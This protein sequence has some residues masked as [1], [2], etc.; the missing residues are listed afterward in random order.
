[1]Y[2]ILKKVKIANPSFYEELVNSLLYSKPCSEKSYHYLRYIYKITNGEF[3]Q[4]VAQLYSLF[5]PKKSSDER[6]QIFDSRQTLDVK[7]IVRNIQ[8]EGIFIFPEKLN[9]NLLDELYRY[10]M[11]LQVT[12]VARKLKLK[13]S[14][15]IDRKKF[16]KSRYI[17]ELADIVSCK[18]FQK[19]VTDA[20]LLSLSQEYL[21][22][23]P[24]LD[25]I[26]L[27][28]SV[29]LN[30]SA[31]L[32]KELSDSA[33]KF[34]YDL[35]RIKFIKFFIYLNEVNLDNGPF[36]Y[37]KG[38]HNKKHPNF[39]DGRY[40][41]EEIHKLY[42][43]DSI[44]EVTGEPGTIFACDTLGF[45]KGKPLKE[46]FRLVLQLEYSISLFGAEFQ[47]Q[48]VDV[49][50]SEVEF[51][52]NLSKNKECYGGRFNLS[53]QEAPKL[54]SKKKK[55]HTFAG[56]P[57]EK[58]KYTVNQNLNSYYSRYVLSRQ[59]KWN[60]KKLLDSSSN[61]IF[62]IGSCFANE[63]RAY[64]NHSSLYQTFPAIPDEVLNRFHSLSKETT[65]WGEWD[66]SSNF[67]HYN[68]FSIRQ[69]IEKAA[70]RWK[71][72]EDDFW[73]LDN[74]GETIF[75]DPYRR[76]IFASSHRELF[77]IIEA[78]DLAIYTGLKSANLAII[79]LGLIEVWRKKNNR[80]ISCCEPKYGGGAG[81][82][83]TEFYLA[84]YQDNYQNVR[85][86]VQILLDYFQIP[87]VVITVSPVPLGRT[88][89]K[90]EVS[91]A[92]VESK[93]VLRSVA[94]QVSSEFENVH[95]FPSYE[96][97]IFDRN[98]YREDG[99]HIHPEKVSQIMDFFSKVHLA[100]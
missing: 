52:Q 13:A 16:P 100:Q 90:L 47:Y 93:S 74:H 38:S 28:F 66:G 8:E 88:F 23:N 29:P 5:R 94:G 46:G 96:M 3:N 27:W 75:Q 24:V 89:R 21:S 31:N 80:L 9:F 83:E 62:T 1:M 61:K 39:K 68:T 49:P 76:K 12:D 58:V 33:Q 48:K 36:T 78:F 30:S 34:H 42:D 55:R 65:S 54:S 15:I 82:Q 14:D 19:I 4:E 53:P 87:N 72:S 17:F 98:S 25:N 43:R 67:Q 20:S 51:L 44:I 71:Q 64:L 97:A 84:T 69:E 45:H 40:E 95:Y 56:A 6:S 22:C 99:R 85:E 26:S 37:V 70:G 7:N 10:V 59:F 18:A 11:N 91:V 35:D 50:K 2:E 86:T 32:D 92:N 77:E 79:T 73:T 60:G 63:L 81:E 41:D 57:Y